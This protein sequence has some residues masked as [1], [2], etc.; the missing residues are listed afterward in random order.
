MRAAETDDN[1]MKTR[2]QQQQRGRPASAGDVRAD[3]STTDLLGFKCGLKGH[4]ARACHLKMWCSLCRSGTHRDVTRRRKKQR[5]DHDDARQ[6][7][8]M[9]EDQDKEDAFRVSDGATG[10]NVKGLMVD[11][12]ATSHVITDLGRFKRFD[13]EFQAETHCV[14]LA[15][16]MKYMGVA[17]RR[18]DAE[19]CMIDSRGKHLNTT[20]SK[21]LYIPTYPQDIF[22][23]QAAT[24]SGATVIFKK[25]ENVLI[26]RDGTRFQI[27]VH[28]RLYYFHTVNHNDDKRDDERRGC[29]DTQTWHEI[30]GHCNYDDIQR[31]Q[32]VVDG[33]NIKGSANKLLHCEVCHL[34]KICQT[35]NRDPDARAKT[36]L[37]LVRTDLV[38]PIHPVSRE[39]HRYALSFTDDYSTAIFVYFLK[40]KGDIV[41]ATEKFLADLAPYGK[42]KCF[43][44]DNGAEYTGKGFQALLIKHGI[45]HETSAP[46]SPHQNVAA[47]RNWRTLFDMARRMLIE[48]NLPKQLW[49]YAVK[50][51]AVVRNRCFNKRTKQ[52]AVQTLTGRPAKPIQ[53]A[54]VWVGV[55]CL[56]TK[57]KKTRSRV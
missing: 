40:K 26:H 55:F 32:N 43:R 15:D 36:P 13:E 9:T 5:R 50:T 54:K 18:G 48:S 31:L 44:S 42:V 45:T 7:S 28:D 14:E 16:G 53:N 37:A 29:F 49:T 25:G 52:T 1:V 22:S 17:E 41:R 33:M 51:A 56:Q 19:V 57:Q 12:G 35:R 47:E 21:A 6:V 30:L 27:H 20:L 8:T 38:G 4:R 10:T 39:G 3:R 24:A 46:Y 34:G 2:M 23:V 11:C